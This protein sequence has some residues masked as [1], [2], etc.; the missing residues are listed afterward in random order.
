MNLIILLSSFLSLSKYCEE[1][2]TLKECRKKEAR[3]SK[4]PRSTENLR[5]GVQKVKRVSMRRVITTLLRLQNQPRKR[6]RPA[7]SSELL[8]TFLQSLGPSHLL[9][10]WLKPS[11]FP[12]LNPLL[13]SGLSP[14]F[15]LSLW[16]INGKNGNSERRYFLGLQNHCRWWLQPWN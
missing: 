9:S 15:L 11:L 8:E 16:V 3:V 10:H 2:A 12:L 7:G 5:I 4:I 14:V 6:L 1:L 13:A